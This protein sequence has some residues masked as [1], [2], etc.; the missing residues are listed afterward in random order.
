MPK[1]NGRKIGKR[2]MTM[3]L[4]GAMAVG[5][6]TGVKMA[7]ESP[8]ANELGQFDPVFYAQMYPD[9]VAVLGADAE[10]LYNHYQNFGQ[11][12]GRIPY[13]GA[14]AGEVVNGI[15]GMDVATQVAVPT[16]VADNIG[17]GPFYL[18]TGEQ[19]DKAAFLQKKQELQQKFDASGYVRVG[20]TEEQVQAKLYSLKEMYPEGMVVGICQTGASKIRN[21]LYGNDFDFVVG[22]NGD[23]DYVYVD[24]HVSCMAKASHDVPL[25]SFLRVGDM[26]YT[27]GGQ[28]LGHVQFVLSRDDNGITIVESNWN[29]EGKMHWGRRISWEELENRENPNAWNSVWRFN[30]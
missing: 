11:K 10:V 21:A 13:A 25:K 6:A 30:Y 24:G 26:L 22:F 20:W 4:V 9:V 14:T 2:I 16:P 3:A 5:T 1:M 7:V 8:Y 15:A 23:D 29:H 28:K 17:N 12:E 18:M 27:V 19:V